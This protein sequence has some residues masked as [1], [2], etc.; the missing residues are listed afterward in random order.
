MSPTGLTLFIEGTQP[1]GKTMDKVRRWYLKYVGWE[2]E[3]AEH[4]AEQLREIVGTL[5]HPDTGVANLLEAVE[6][7]YRSAGLTPPRWVGRVRQRIGATS[8]AGLDA[9]VVLLSQESA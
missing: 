2:S 3:K 8:R 6:R 7:S 5:P 1:Y 4:I 9:G